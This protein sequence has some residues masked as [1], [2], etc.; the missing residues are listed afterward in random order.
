MVPRSSALTNVNEAPDD[1][2]LR[3]ADHSGVAKFSSPNDP[4]YELLKE[5]IQKY[6]HEAQQ[7]VE[8]HER[9]GAIGIAKNNK[10][11]G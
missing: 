4:E 8:D 5:K 10:T 1:I 2:L 7:A 11:L 9:P 3:D 6:V